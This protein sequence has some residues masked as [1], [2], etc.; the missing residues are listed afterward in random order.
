MFLFLSI[1]AVVEILLAVGLGS[2]YRLTRKEQRDLERR[3]SQ[4]TT[5]TVLLRMQFWYLTKTKRTLRRKWL[6]ISGNT[7]SPFYLLGVS[8]QAQTFNDL[9]VL[10]AQ[11]KETLDVPYTDIHYLQDN[12]TT[13][14]TERKEPQ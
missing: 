12:L 3:I 14:T 7:N 5:R 8:D 9:D 6:R 11:E 2:L 10:L 1:L 4:V 13:T